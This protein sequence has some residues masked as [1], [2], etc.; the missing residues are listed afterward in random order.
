VNDDKEKVI[1]LK[2]PANS[3]LLLKAE[4]TQKL[5]E[6][7]NQL[8][9]SI[10]HTNANN[11]LDCLDRAVRETEYNIARTDRK[12]ITALC[13]GIEAVLK[14]E[15]RRTAIFGNLTR[16]KEE[17]MYLGE[18]YNALQ[19]FETMRKLGKYSD[20]LICAENICQMLIN[21]N[22]NDHSLLYNE[23]LEERVREL[24]SSLVDEDI[25]KDLEA[26]LK[27]VQIN[28]PN[29]I[30]EL[31]LFTDITHNLLK[32]IE[33]ARKEM[34]AYS[35]TIIPI[36]DMKLLEIPI[37]YYKK[38]CHW[39]MVNFLEDKELLN[40][41]ICK[42]ERMTLHRFNTQKENPAPLLKVDTAK[43]KS[44]ILEQPKSRPIYRGN[45]G[46]LDM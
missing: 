7:Y 15:E 35:K 23:E 37:K 40:S 38:S 12:E 33:H 9:Y 10:I 32:K 2:L 31:E 16:Y 44:E 14:T 41:S 24:M 6:W 22:L 27:Y 26:K 18:L 30:K 29:H 11:N 3:N 13:T 28:N 19:A 4:S 39:T 1:R 46:I 5:N 17:Y 25:I 20:A 36:Q 21:F 45:S 42:R 43:N 34:R 8:Q